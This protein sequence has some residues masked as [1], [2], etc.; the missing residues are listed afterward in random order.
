[1]KF[2]IIKEFTK[3]KRERGSYVEQLSDPEIKKKI[4]IE[5]KKRNVDKRRK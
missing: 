4:H 1:M 3:Q 2:K 5:S